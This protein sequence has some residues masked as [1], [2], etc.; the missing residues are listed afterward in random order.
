MNTRAL[1]GVASLDMLCFIEYPDGHQVQ[2]HSEWQPT[3]V[4]VHMSDCV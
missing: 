2:H 3:G 4:F 1:P